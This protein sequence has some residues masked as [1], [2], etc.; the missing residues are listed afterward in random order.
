MGAFGMMSQTTISIT[1]LQTLML[2]AMRD[3]IISIY[4]LVY[5]ASVP[6]GSLLVGAVSQRIGVQPAVLAEGILILL[7]TLLCLQNLRK[8]KAAE[9][10]IA[11]EQAAP[12]VASVV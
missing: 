11:T 9:R 2:P 12:E 10:A 7:I 4:V 6:L 5:T 8:V 3:R 1:L